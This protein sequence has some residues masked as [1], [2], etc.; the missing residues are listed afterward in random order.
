MLGILGNI[1]DYDEARPIV[2]R[3]LDGVPSG[4]YLVINDGTD[5]SE[6]IKEGARVSSQGGHPY[7]LR[8]PEEIARF[9]DGL[10][11]EEPGV[12]CTPR[13]RPEPSPNGLP[14]ELDA[15]CGV[16]RKP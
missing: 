14:A 1:A 16:A 9:F 2:K 8:S 11:L 10:Q 12:I 7:T 13:W 5:T 4:S 3:L 15:A 6:E